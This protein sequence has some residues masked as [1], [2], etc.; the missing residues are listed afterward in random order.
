MTVYI[1]PLEPL[2]ERYTYSWYTNIPLAFKQEFQNIVIIDGEPLSDYVDAGTFLDINSTVHYKSTQLAKISE[3]FHQ[4]R[5]KNGDIFFVADIEF[6]GIE[7]IRF[8]ADLQG[9]KVGLFGFCHAASYTIEDFMEPAAPYSRFFELGWLAAFD[10]IFVGSRYHKNAI[11]ERRINPLVVSEAD[12]QAMADKIVVTG[13]PLFLT[14]YDLASDQTPKLKQMIISNRFDWEKRPNLSL[15]F[16]Y[17]LKRRIPDLNIIVTTSRPEFKSNKKWLV[18]LARCME[19]DGIIKIYDGLT[20]KEYHALL[21]ESRIFLTNTIEEN[22]GYCLIEAVLHNTY[23]LAENKYSHPELLKNDSR[24]LFD[25]TD[26]IV[27][28]AISLLDA[29]HDISDMAKRYCKS[30]ERM[31][32]AIKFAIS[33][34]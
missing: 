33:Y 8:M 11:I 21:A 30:M 1:I 5:I 9:I 34:K 16:C 26:E 10:L 2:E 17:I 24:F 3:L 20:K 23:P 6:W 14:D 28:K 27:P 18:E 29:D 31:I 12:R 22:F 19:N 4:K 32:D 7:S 13:N 25:D 15:D